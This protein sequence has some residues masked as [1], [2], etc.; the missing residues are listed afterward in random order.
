MGPDAKAC[1]LWTGESR[2]HKWHGMGLTRDGRDAGWDDGASGYRP[3]NSQRCGWSRVDRTA[4]DTAGGG[5]AWADHQRKGQIR[6]PGG[7]KGSPGWTRTNNPAINSRM[8]CQLSYGGPGA[9][10]PHRAVSVQHTRVGALARGATLVVQPAPLRTVYFPAIPAPHA[11]G[12]A[13]L[14]P[15]WAIPHAA[16][17]FGPGGLG[18]VRAGSKR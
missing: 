4:L 12:S 5:V 10:S 13:R 2:V 9:K 16:G 14:V 1:P 17:R 11:D 15:P 3:A 18:K 8:L 7:G 6:R